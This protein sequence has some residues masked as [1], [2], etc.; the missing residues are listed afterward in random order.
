MR[1][2]GRSRLST[3]DLLV[4]CVFRVRPRSYDSRHGEG[5]EDDA[6][7]HLRRSLWTADWQVRLLPA[8][9]QRGDHA[10]QRHGKVNCAVSIIIIIIIII[11]T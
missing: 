6:G 10:R 1:D 2:R 11:V 4:A 8:R 7:F 3:I 5:Q 9:D